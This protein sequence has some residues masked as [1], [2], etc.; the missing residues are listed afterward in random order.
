MIGK[1]IKIMIDTHFTENLNKEANFLRCI[2]FEGSSNDIVLSR[3]ERK[4]NSCAANCRMI[5]EKPRS[6]NIDNALTLV[7]S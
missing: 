5:L 1:A 2:S 6:A 3:K 4:A 7:N